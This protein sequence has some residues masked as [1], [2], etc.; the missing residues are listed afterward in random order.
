MATDF[1]GYSHEQLLA[2]I[3]SLDAETVKARATQLAEASKAIKSIGE[4]LKKHQ[5][6]GWEGEAARAFQSWVSQAGS[7]TLRLGEYSAEGSKW[8]THAAQT[9]IEVKANTPKY[10]ASAAANLEAAHRF[11]NDPDAQQ[12]GRTAHSKLTADHQQAVQ[13]LTKLA[14]SYEA[15]TTQLNKAEVPTFPPPPPDYDPPAAVGSDTVISRP[16][17]GPGGSG[18]GGSAYASA[19]LAEPAGLPGP[20]TSASGPEGPSGGHAPGGIGLVPTPLLIGRDVNVDLDSA[21]TLPVSSLPLVNA[22]PSN[23]VTGRGGN[24][25]PVVPGPPLV[26]PPT[27][28]PNMPR[29]GF[30]TNTKPPAGI[31]AG[32]VVGLPPHDT[33]IV[34][35]RPVS[36]GTPNTSIPRGTVIGAEGAHPVGRGPGGSVSGGLGGPH[37]PSGGSPVGRRLATEPGGVVGG[38]QSAV[39]GRSAVGGQPFTQ[40][41]AGLVRNS[42]AAGHAGAGTR[43]PGMRRGEQG[44]ERPG[45]LAEDGETWQTDRRV[46]PPVID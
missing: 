15:S 17:N 2:M 43:S 33:G 8:M 14:Q 5:V 6:K 38:R 32:K 20:H 9:M 23:A 31:G 12:M 28:G 45:Y 4:S 16:G 3:A 7:A 40:G 44:G 22:L 18:F 39:G 37:G 10:D 29:G 27:A 34:G 21:A 19:A 41:G 1:E 11:H 42:G 25:N 36:S 35:G 26:L 24:A 30:L 13:Q 46:V